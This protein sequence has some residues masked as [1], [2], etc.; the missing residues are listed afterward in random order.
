MKKRVAELIGS[1]ESK[2]WPSMSSQR[3]KKDGGVSLSEVVAPKGKDKKGNG[4]MTPPL[5]N[6]ATK[7]KLP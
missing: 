3:E 4:D 7:T 2:C 1:K 6:L 5:T